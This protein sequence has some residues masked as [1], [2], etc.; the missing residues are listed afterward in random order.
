MPFYDFVRVEDANGV[1]FTQRA[2]V[3]RDGVTVVDEP[4]THSDGTPL[5]PEYPQKKT[6]Q[7][8]DPEKEKN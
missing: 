1:K 4:A 2:S 3:P 6:G 7:K 5:P 8:A